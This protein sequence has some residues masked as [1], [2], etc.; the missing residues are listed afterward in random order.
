MLQRENALR[1]RCFEEKR[2][3]REGELKTEKRERV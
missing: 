3:E 1:R 2:G